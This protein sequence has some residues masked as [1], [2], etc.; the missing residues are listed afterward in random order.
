MAEIRVERKKKG[1]PLIYILLALI[2]LA[3]AAWM[4]LDDDDEAV[5]TAPAVSFLETA[6]SSIILRAA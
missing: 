3:I 2:A 1:I 5:E 4:L 6:P